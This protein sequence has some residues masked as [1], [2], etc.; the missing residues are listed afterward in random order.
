MTDALVQFLRARLDEDEQTARIISCGG[1]APEV[2]R[3]EPVRSRRWMQIVPFERGLLE[4]PG[5]E[6]RASDSPTVLVANN[7]A[8]WAHIERWDPARVVAEVDAK[9]RILDECEG[10]VNHDS[11]GM[12]SM[13]DSVLSLLALPYADHPDY[14][15]EWA[16]GA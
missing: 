4:P 3:A 6:Y 12:M 2:W 5:S 7:R 9:R 13:A 11:R 8:E 1:F 14:R 15:P 10:A 16:P